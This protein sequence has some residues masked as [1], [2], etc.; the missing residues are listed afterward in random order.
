MKV[1][2]ILNILLLFLNLKKVH[3]IILINGNKNLRLLIN[4]NK[5]HRIS[6]NISQALFRY[7]GVNYHNNNYQKVTKVNKMKYHYI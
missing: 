3:K 2:K 7:Q 6:Q 4:S 1:L 5:I